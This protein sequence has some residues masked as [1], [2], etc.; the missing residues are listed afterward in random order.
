MRD[1]ASVREPTAEEWAAAVFVP[2]KAVYAGPFHYH[3]GHM[4]ADGIHRLWPLAIDPALA[5]A[6]IVFQMR[7][8]RP[9]TILPWLTELLSLF[10]IV[11]DQLC[12]V[13]APMRFEELHVA[14][15]GRMLGGAMP[16]AEYP[17]LFPLSPIEPERTDAPG[18]YV[19]R[20]QHMFSGSYLGESLIETL[21][22]RAG[23]E[24]VYPETIPLKGL[25]RKLAGARRIIFSEGSAIHNLELIGRV[26]APILVIGRRKGT[27]RRFRQVLDPLCR[28]WSVFEAIRDTVPLDWDARRQKPGMGARGSS[29][30]DLAGL[31][32]TLAQFTGLD[33]ATQKEGNLRRAEAMDLLHVL[34]DPR[35]GGGL[36]DEQ[37][38]QVVR[39]VQR[40]G[41][42]EGL[43]PKP[44]RSRA[45]R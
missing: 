21:L 7:P 3:F 14:K 16:V 19:S 29:F 12:F 35:T 27:E 31:I 38:G 6:R 43:M 4:V 45:P 11:P 17:D 41:L 2:G 42:V 30:L 33:L 40:T 32:G 15:Q 18:L 26:E 5:G 36:T 9:A 22:A 13:N 8:A 34:I 24:I 25:L 23:Y 37:F 44:R 1:I 28:D 39:A 10:G 20:R